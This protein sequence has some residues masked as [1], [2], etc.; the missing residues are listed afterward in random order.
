MNLMVFFVIGGSVAILLLVVGIVVSV[1]SEHDIVDERI[2]QYVDASVMEEE[3]RSQASTPL[4]DWINRR[5]EGS[6]IG[7]KISK[8]LARADLKLKPGE[9]IAVMII[10]GFGV[11]MI[12]WFFTGQNILMGVLGIPVGM[13]LPFM[14]LKSQQGKRLLKFNEQLP[15]M[16]NLMVN[17]LRAGFSTMQ[18]MEAVSRELP[19]PICDEFRRVVQEMQL[20]V[21]MEK[22]LDNLLRR[23]PSDDLDLVITAINVQREV[24]GNLAEIMDTIS[25]TIRERVRIKGE[26]RVLTAQVMYSGKF[27]AMMPLFVIGILYLLNRSYMMEFFLPENVPCG[28]LALALGAILIISGYFAMTKLGEI[29]V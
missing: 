16:L 20:G 23:I 7:D 28:Y 25:Y 15:D 17:G 22:A 14:W 12:L 1:R 27:L 3:I 9:F 10:A 8:R 2:G 19:P 26:I 29:E 6:S 18:A 5:M 24:G 21:S 11:G 13:W 4:T